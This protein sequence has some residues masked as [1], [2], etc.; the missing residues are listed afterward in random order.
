VKPLQEAGVD[1]GGAEEHNPHRR[2][3]TPARSEALV[4]QDRP[5]AN[6]EVNSQSPWD[7]A[8]QAA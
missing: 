6:A 7:P 3:Q 8:A 5:L 1:R 2:R 4:Q